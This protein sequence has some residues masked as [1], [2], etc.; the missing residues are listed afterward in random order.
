LLPLQRMAAKLKHNIAAINFSTS[1]QRTTTIAA[2]RTY[3][4]QD[5]SCRS[6]AGDISIACRSSDA[7]W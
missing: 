4:I 7:Q 6:D 5:A 3:E 1:S 2:L